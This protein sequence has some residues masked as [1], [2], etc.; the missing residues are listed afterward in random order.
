MMLYRFLFV[1]GYVDDSVFCSC[2]TFHCRF[3]AFSY[4]LSVLCIVL[5]WFTSFLMYIG[6]NYFIKILLWLYRVLV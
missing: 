3:V 2:S 1:M 6:C 4:R 5:A